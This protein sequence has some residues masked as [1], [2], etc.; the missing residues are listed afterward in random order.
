MKR[1]LLKFRRFGRFALFAPFILA[2]ACGGTSSKSGAPQQLT[3]QQ[4]SGRDLFNRTCAGCHVGD[5]SSG[6]K[7]P[8]LAGLFRKQYLPSGLPANDRF[9]EQT[10]I[11]GRGVMPG[12]G[13]ALGDEQLADLMA[14]LH[15]L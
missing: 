8:K 11:G 5:S 4:T 12:M 7:G 13:D 2:A 6:A 10:I 15:A 1:F 9:V 3:P 14:Y